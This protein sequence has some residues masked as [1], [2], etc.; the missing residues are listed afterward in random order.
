MS[1]PQAR[2]VK[3]AIQSLL[4]VVLSSGCFSFTGHFGAPIPVTRVNDIREGVTTRADITAWFG[5]PS[6]FYRPS[7]VDLITARGEDIEAPN[8]PIIEDVY[9]YRYIENRA[10]IWI[11]PIVM[12]RARATTQTQSLAVFFDEAGVVRYYGYREDGPDGEIRGVRYD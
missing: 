5:P 12:L 3:L 6:A 2:S 4:I 10:R 8:A 9:S 11:I 1:A 7:L